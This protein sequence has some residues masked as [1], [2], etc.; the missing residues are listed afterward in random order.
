MDLIKYEERLKLHNWNY[1]QSN[2]FVIWQSGQIEF[3]KL[4]E[5]SFT[6][7]EHRNLFLQYKKQAGII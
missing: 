4:I 7:P 6:S 2:N 5:L 1:Q 3:K